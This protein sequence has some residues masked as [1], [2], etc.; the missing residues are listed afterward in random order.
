MS[1]GEIKQ[2][3]GPFEENH[4]INLNGNCLI[5]FSLSEDD[6]MLT[7]QPTLN[8]PKNFSFIINNKEIQMGRTFIYQTGEQINNTIISFPNGA[9]AS[10]KINVAYYPIN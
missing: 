2:Y 7:A 10:L 8:P 1:L 4:S 6:F 3:T 5:G 9:P